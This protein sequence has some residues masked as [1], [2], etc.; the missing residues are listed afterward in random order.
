MV[1][2]GS[3][4]LQG[5]MGVINMKERVFVKQATAAERETGAQRGAGVGEEMYL[6]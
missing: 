5:Q 4:C 2:V 6:N 1:L 3:S